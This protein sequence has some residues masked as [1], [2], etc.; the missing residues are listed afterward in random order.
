LAQSL[1]GLDVGDRAAGCETQPPDVEDQPGFARLGI[2][3]L[4]HEHD[5]PVR[6]GDQR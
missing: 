3:T 6:L 4:K 1:A 2:I 5:S